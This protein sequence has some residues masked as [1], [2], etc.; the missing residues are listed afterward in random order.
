MENLL[1]KIL[2]NRMLLWLLL[3]VFSFLTIFPM[4]IFLDNIILYPINSISSLIS[5]N[6]FIFFL[7]SFFY[8][9]GIETLIAINYGYMYVKYPVWTIYLE[10]QAD[11]PRIR[12]GKIT[13]SSD[14]F[15]LI[16]SGNKIHQINKE[17]IIE[18]QRRV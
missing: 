3:I 10:G 13:E 4:L 12:R 16:K 18:I 1:K 14:K 11:N 7:S 8:W 6:S 17:K 5:G 15:V 9:F 2:S